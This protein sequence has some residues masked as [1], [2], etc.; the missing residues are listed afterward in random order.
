MTKPMY[1]ETDNIITFDPI[2]NAET[3]VIR[4]D[5]EKIL[6]HIFPIHDLEDTIFER[7]V[8]T[9]ITIDG[10]DVSKWRP[11]VTSGIKV[12]QVI[13]HHI[14]GKS[15]LKYITDKYGNEVIE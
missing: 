13:K 15:M 1:K 10:D 2:L 6:W 9:K 7:E 11:H 8:E 3:Y 4:F 14:T 5:N 12:L